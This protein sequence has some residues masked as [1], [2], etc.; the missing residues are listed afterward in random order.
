[1]GSCQLRLNSFLSASTAFAIWL[2]YD[3]VLL[4]HCRDRSVLVAMSSGWRAPGFVYKKNFQNGAMLRYGPWSAFRG[5]FACVHPGFN[6]PC[7]I[8][9][10]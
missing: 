6:N 5:G 1:M 9:T 10:N 8:L 7:L 3:V 2:I 4:D